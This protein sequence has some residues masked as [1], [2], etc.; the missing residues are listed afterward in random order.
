MAMVKPGESRPSASR[1]SQPSTYDVVSAPPLMPTTLTPAVRAAA[2]RGGTEMVLMLE[3]PSFEASVDQ[4]KPT[5][6]D[7]FSAG[8]LDAASH[9]ESSTARRNGAST[10]QTY[11]SSSVC[12]PIEDE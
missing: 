7:R 5:A 2:P 3:K 9:A 8:L 10:P 11:R 6:Q 4:E 1:T 12:P